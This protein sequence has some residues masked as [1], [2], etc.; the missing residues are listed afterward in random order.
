[1]GNLVLFL[2][3]FKWFCPG[4]GGDRGVCPGIFA[5]ALVPG[6]R[7]TRTRNFFVPRDVP[8]LGNTT[9]NTQPQMIPAIVIVYKAGGTDIELGY[10]TIFAIPRLQLP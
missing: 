5:P 4:M 6:Q 9:S 7:D 10:H 1:M 3:N 8:S 2:K